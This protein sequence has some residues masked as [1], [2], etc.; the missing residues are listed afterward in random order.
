MFKSSRFSN[1]H[2]NVVSPMERKILSK[3]VEFFE[4]KKE[5]KNKEQSL[6]FTKLIKNDVDVAPLTEVNHT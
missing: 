1:N 3:V 2:D 4:N 5:K 6:N